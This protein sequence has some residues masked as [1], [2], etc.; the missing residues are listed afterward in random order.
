MLSVLDWARRYVGAG[1]SVIPVRS[2]GSKA[3]AQKNWRTFTDRLPTAEELIEW[4]GGEHDFG[5]GV[6]PGPASG[7]L[8]VLD[9]E[10]RHGGS[11]FEEWLRTTPREVY[12]HISDCPIIITPSGGRHV[13]IRNAE[14]R[15]G[16]VLAR[17][18]AGLVKIEIRGTGQQVLAPG[19]PVKCHS[20][21][22][23][24]TFEQHGW[25]PKW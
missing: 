12:A 19:C 23:P 8:A 21:G 7:N 6:V 11:A 10:V 24:Y 16:T 25:L 4:F 2:D 18:A 14:P 3:P 13:W 9:F 1:L 5:L 17:D 20:S 22:K 15:K